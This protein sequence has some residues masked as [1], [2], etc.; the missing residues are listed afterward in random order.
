MLVSVL[1]IAAAFTVRGLCLD[2]MTLDY[3]DF[4]SKW[5]DFYR[6]NGGFKALHYPLGNYNIPYSLFPVSVLLFVDKR[7]LSDKAAEHLL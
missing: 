6:Q 7:P 1:L 3:K 5:V 4:L 2:Y